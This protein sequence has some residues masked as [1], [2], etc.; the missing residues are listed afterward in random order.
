VG[1]NPV[2]LV[3]PTGHIPQI[4]IDTDGGGGQVSQAEIDETLQKVADYQ[5]QQ[6]AKQAAEAQARIEAGIRAGQR[7]YNS[8]NDPEVRSSGIG[9]HLNV[10]LQKQAD[11]QWGSVQ[12]GFSGHWNMANS[13]CFVTSLFMA[14]ANVTG[15]TLDGRPNLPI[16]T[17]REEIHL[18]P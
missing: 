14:S 1:N 17:P 5:A 15:K 10:P 11:H 6:A 2:N 8:Y 7:L 12:L 18:G 4:L 16:S 13:G 9:V 3:D